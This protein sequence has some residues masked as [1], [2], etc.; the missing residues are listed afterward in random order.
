MTAS[1]LASVDIFPLKKTDTCESAIVFMHDWK[2]FQLP[3]TD[4]GK[5]IGYVVLSDLAEAS[6]KH[7]I[8][9]YIKPFLQL[10]CVNNQHLFGL[11]KQFAESKFT[12]LAISDDDNNYIGAVSLVDLNIVLYKSSLSQSGAIVVLKMSPQDYSLAELSR[13]IEYNDCKILNVFIT[14]DSSDSTKILLSVKLNKQNISTVLQTLE[15]YNY[16]INSI[17]ELDDH[18]ASLDQRYD[19]LIKYLNT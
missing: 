1:E 3:V 4:N 19:W 13:I 8:D 14:P 16:T 5:L 7:K 10:Y 11:I 18:Q 17:Y 9:K 15:R 12:C 6:P 2:V